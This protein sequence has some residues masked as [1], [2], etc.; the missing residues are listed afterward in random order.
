MKSILISILFIFLQTVLVSQKSQNILIEI[1]SIED[2]VIP[3]AHLILDAAD[4]Y[5]SNKKGQ[6]QI[7]STSNLLEV[8][9][10]HIGY[11]ELDTTINIKQNQV[12]TIFLKSSSY[13]ID[14]V[15]ISDK[16][17]LFEKNNW[18]ITDIT[19]HEYGFV[20]SA[21]ENS[22]KHIY[23]F[24]KNGVQILKTRTKFKHNSII[25]GLKIGHFHLMNNI[26]G[27]EIMVSTDTII[28]LNIE[29]IE[30]YEKT[31]DHFKFTNSNYTIAEEW[32]AH[33]KRFTLSIID[34]RTFTKE[35]FY[36]SFDEE[37]YKRSQS[38]YREIIGLYFKDS[39]KA[40]PLAKPGDISDNIV[41]DGT[42]SGDLVDLLVTD[43]IQEV[44]NYYKSLYCQEVA[45]STKVTN[46]QLFI[47]DDHKRTMSI[48]G[49]DQEYV[50]QEAQ[51]IRIPDVIIKGQF[52]NSSQDDELIILSEDEYYSFD[53]ST[54]TFSA[55]EYKQK[56]YYY[57]KTTFMDKN[58]LYV[59]AQKSRIKHK[60]SIFRCDK[61]EHIE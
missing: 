45:V 6:I 7:H 27:Q 32:A 12:H 3:S 18:S 60:K 51:E 23:L 1:R 5:I 29:P 11:I 46:D 47:L 35:P 2:V 34:N 25:H 52:M 30:T 59:L 14:P 57:P 24:D 40:N 42:W 36:I 48:Y 15:T 39:Y 21:T 56:D 58:V 19:Y 22:K 16:Q 31:L 43:T 26:A 33:N 8:Q 17:R 20:V 49:L 50:S 10:S 41:Q 55:I 37:N 38:V 13:I 44:Y 28:F 54:N 9:I 53:L 61:L 4:H